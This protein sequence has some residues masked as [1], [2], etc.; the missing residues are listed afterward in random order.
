MFPIFG[1]HLRRGSVLRGHCNDRVMV[2][3][4]LNS[5]TAFKP[6][7]LLKSLFSWRKPQH[8]RAAKPRSRAATDTAG[9]SGMRK[10]F[11]HICWIIKTTVAVVT[12]LC[13]KRL[14]RAPAS[15]SLPAMQICNT[16]GLEANV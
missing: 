8:L 13:R 5:S 4:E 1:D 6:T 15:L 7:I 3:M 2:Q 16:T 9:V 14:N 11:H 12:T 10:G